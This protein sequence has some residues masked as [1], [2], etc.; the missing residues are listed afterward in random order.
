MCKKAIAVDQ[1]LKTFVKEGQKLEITSGFIKKWAEKAKELGG[2]L[3]AARIQK[4]ISVLKLKV[5]LSPCA[6]RHCQSAGWSLQL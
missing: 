1:A 6:I 3:S 4:A 2:S 5:T